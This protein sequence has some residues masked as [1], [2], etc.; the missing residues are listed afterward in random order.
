MEVIDCVYALVYISFDRR[1]NLYAIEGQPFSLDDVFEGHRGAQAWWGVTS[2]AQIESESIGTWQETDAFSMSAASFG[3]E[4]RVVI[5][6]D[7]N[8]KDS[9]CP[10]EII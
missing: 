7:R 6:Y 2:G 5:S 8:P 9:T 10:L 1:G 3:D 4:T